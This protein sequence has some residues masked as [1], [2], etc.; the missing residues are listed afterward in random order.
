MS[1]DGISTY[2][3]RPLIRSSL[4][5]SIYDRMMREEQLRNYDRSLWYKIDDRL[6]DCDLKSKFVQSKCDRETIQFIE[7]CYEKSEWFF[8]HLFHAITRTLL[9]LF[10]TSTSVNGLLNRGSMFIFSDEQFNKLFEDLPALKYDENSRLLDIGAGDGRVTEIM[11]KY[12]NKT[13]A[14]EMSPIMKHILAKKG[15]QLLDV[16]TWY[17]DQCSYDLISCMNVLDRCERPLSMLERIKT[18]LKPNGKLLL[19]IVFPLSQYVENSKN[20]HKPIETINVTGDTLEQQVNSFHKNVIE[21]HG[22]RLISWTKLPY[23]CEGDMELSFYWLN[24]VIML[25]EPVHRL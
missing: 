23:L 7:S 22:F 2:N 5:R 8:T 13:F 15:F 9:T 19:A 21:A 6:I 24:D 20:R 17:K 11:A 16:D 18:K 4:A 12:F 10:M 25:L 14:T 3:Y 1:N